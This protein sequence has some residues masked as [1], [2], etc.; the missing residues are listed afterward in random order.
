V[1]LFFN[2]C[3]SQV[4]KKDREIINSDSTKNHQKQADVANGQEIF[5]SHCNMCHGSPTHNIDGPN[6]FN[7][8]FQ[9]LPNPSDQYFLRFIKDGE[10]L[11]KIEDKY[12]RKLDSFYKI[13]VLHVYK[14]KLSDSQLQDLLA[15]VREGN[16]VY[17]DLLK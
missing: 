6:I 5:R 4:S 7:N 14:E 9:R 15:Y 2:L 11:K 3:C 17:S 12:Y 16:K 8:L 1:T 10:Q 13:S